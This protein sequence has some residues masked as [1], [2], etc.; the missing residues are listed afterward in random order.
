MP[1]QL[2][3]VCRILLTDFSYKAPSDDTQPATA[4]SVGGSVE[5]GP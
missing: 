5:P 2:L 1:G 4:P 3:P